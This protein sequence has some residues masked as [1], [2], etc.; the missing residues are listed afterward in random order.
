MMS[1]LRI[2]VACAVL[3]F[4]LPVISGIALAIV[5]AAGWSAGALTTW[6]R[7]AGNVVADG[8]GL[9]ATYKE[10][11]L[12]IWGLAALLAV[13]GHTLLSISL[14]WVYR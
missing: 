8:I 13:G 12:T 6:W 10:T 5:D 14:A 7:L 2:L 3:V 11:M 1:I 9:S 4:Y